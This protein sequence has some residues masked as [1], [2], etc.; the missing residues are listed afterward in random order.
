[1]G[2]A[3]VVLGVVTHVHL[4]EDLSWLPITALVA[5]IFGYG[6]GVLSIPYIILAEIF[7]LQVSFAF[8]LLSSQFPRE[9]G[10]LSLAR[11]LQNSIFILAINKCDPVHYKIK[12]LRH[13]FC[14]LPV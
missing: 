2:V 4:S 1:M 13:V 12:L 11:Q 8:Y 3:L 6:I 7:N 14:S 5:A 9:F 10:I